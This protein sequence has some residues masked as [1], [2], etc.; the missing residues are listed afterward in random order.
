MHMF[1]VTFIYTKI[2]K[3]AKVIL[4]AGHALHDKSGLVRTELQRFTHQRKLILIN[5]PYKSL[6]CITK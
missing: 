3:E 1:I 6:F 2:Y 4:R 5:Y